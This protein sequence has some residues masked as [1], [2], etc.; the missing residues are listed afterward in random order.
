MP[1]DC[2]C[3]LTDPYPFAIDECFD[4]YRLLVESGGRVIGMAGHKL[5]VII[6]GDSE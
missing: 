4:V 3:L 2:L 5:N 1:A 6:S